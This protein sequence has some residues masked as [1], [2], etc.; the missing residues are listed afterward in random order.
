MKLSISSLLLLS[1]LRAWIFPAVVR[2]E[3]LLAPDSSSDFTQRDYQRDWERFDVE[4]GEEEDRSV[5][6]GDTVHPENVE[7]P[8]SPVLAKP[9]LEDD[10]LER[11]LLSKKKKCN[12][13]W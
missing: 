4:E 2:G 6:N 13:R 5:V 3:A 8:E 9:G 12:L 11:L 7:A 10:E 1:T